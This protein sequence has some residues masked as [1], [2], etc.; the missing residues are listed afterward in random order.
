[1]ITP[2][3]SLVPLSG[4]NLRGVC[5]NKADQSGATCSSGQKQPAHLP[6][7]EYGLNGP[8]IPPAAGA[9]DAQRVTPDFLVGRVN[10]ALWS[11]SAGVLLAA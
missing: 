8:G 1:V 6:L 7:V 10:F 9:A 11:T 2:V 4:A 5:L 3:L